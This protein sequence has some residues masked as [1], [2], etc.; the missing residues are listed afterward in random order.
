MIIKRTDEVTSKQV[1][2]SGIDTSFEEDDSF[3]PLS[4]FTVSKTDTNELTASADISKDIVAGDT[5]RVNND[6]NDI[7]TVDSVVGAVI[8]T[9]ETTNAAASVPIE[10]G[11]FFLGEEIG[12]EA[13]TVIFNDSNQWES[14]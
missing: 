5:I 8:T 9:N 7:Y 13:I 6:D 14:V 10:V 12:K 11:G 3:N 1:R 4:S 2:I